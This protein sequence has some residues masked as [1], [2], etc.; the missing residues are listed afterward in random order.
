MRGNVRRSVTSVCP[1]SLLIG[2]SSLG[3]DVGVDVEVDVEVDVG[4]DVHTHA[5]SLISF[6][7]SVFTRTHHPTHLLQCCAFASHDVQ[8]RGGRTGRLVTPSKLV[9]AV[10]TSRGGW[11]W[12]ARSLGRFPGIRR[13]DQRICRPWSPHLHEPR[14]RSGSSGDL[15]AR[16]I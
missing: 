2:Y 6:V 15:C 12:G 8:V 5:S 16:N 11:R 4:V 10:A 1:L 9:L 14:Q 7:P 3:V 13:P